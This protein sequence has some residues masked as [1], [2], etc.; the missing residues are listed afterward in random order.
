MFFAHSDIHVLY[1]LENHGVHA[2]P[3]QVGPEFYAEDEIER[4]SEECYLYEKRLETDFTRDSKSCQPPCDEQFPMLRDKELNNQFVE[5][6]LQYQ[7]KEL[8]DY[9]NEFDFQYSD[10]TDE[11]LTLLIDMLFDSRDVYSRHKFHVSK[12]RRKFHVTLKPKAELK[13]NDPAKYIYT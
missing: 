13:T 10:N 12:T 9:I 3:S 5:H 4:Y 7:P 2:L 11:E 8:V 1:T 6:Y